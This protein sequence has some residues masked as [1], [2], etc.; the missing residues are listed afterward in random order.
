MLVLN[1][2]LNIAINT[3][4]YFNLT[5]DGS[6]YLAVFGSSNP[7]FI[8]QFYKGFNRKENKY[9][10]SLINNSRVNEGEVNFGE[11]IAGIKGFYANV[12]MSTDTTTNPGGE[13]QLFQV[14]TSYKANNGY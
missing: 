3:I 9:V 12:T 8:N 4:L 7:G 14:S 10:A 6:N 5:V 1:Q 2:D 11:Q 13:K